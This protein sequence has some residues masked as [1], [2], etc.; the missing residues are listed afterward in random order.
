MA[1]NTLQFII[2]AQ[3]NAKQ[4]FD[5]VAA[6]LKNLQ[7]SAEG[8]KKSW[9]DTVSASQEVAIG[10]AAA[11]AAAGGFA[12]SAI[13]AAASMEQSLISYETM[14]GSA[15]KAQQFYKGLVE[16]AAKTPFTLK[17]LDESA[18]KLLA[19]G[20]NTEEVM[21]N[22]K[23]LGD[24]S[25]GVG[26][27]KLPLL[28][29][30]LGQ[31][32]AAGKMMGDT[33][34]Q[35][36]ENGVPMLE[37]LSAT[38]GKSTAE[39]SEMVSAG[40]IGRPEV[41]AALAA[42]SGEGGRFNN[43]MDKQSKSLAGLWSNL[44]DAWDQFLTGQGAM[45]LDWAKKL[46]AVLI[47]IVQNKLPAWTAQMKDLGGYL[48]KNK[49]T[50]IILAVAITSMLI[51]AAVDATLA[52]GS[53]MVALAPFAVAGGALAGLVTGLEQGNVALTTISGA[54]LALFIP[55]VIAMTTALYGAIVPMIPLIASMVVAFAPFFIGGAIVA[56]LVAGTI[57]IVQN[58][59]LVKTKVTEIWGGIAVY[60]SAAWTGITTSAQT[61]W[62]GITV[63][64]QGVWDGI[65]TVF[66][67]GAS[68]AVGLVMNYFNLFGIDIIAVWQ[69][70]TLTLQLAWTAI[71]QAF[72]ASMTFLQG[73]W[74]NVWTAIKN[75]ITPIW[76][77]I[78]TTAKGGFDWIVAKFNEVTAPINEAWTS[79]WKGV[80]QVFTTVWEGVKETIK[81]SFNWIIEK[82]NSVI[83]ALNNVA[84]TGADA[85]GFDSF[86]IPKIPALA[87]GG[88]VTRP[89]LAL[90]GEAG[91]EAVLPLSKVGGGGYGPT[92]YLTLT[93]NTFIGEDDMSDKISKQIMD[94]LRLNLKMG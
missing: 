60:L 16:F 68:L 19:Y 26:M 93:G 20:F 56:G 49:S 90:I 72:Q 94:T 91:P 13:K 48:E 85:L 10:F 77:G 86:Q 39:I 43:L 78:K 22:I 62:G 31:T 65:K 24:I 88:I 70:I 1:D 36:T 81:S 33:L 9:A 46:V 23:S 58:W 38:M 6:Q 8:M 89:T 29:L 34:R 18:K 30:A 73:I 55:S 66:E 41:Q 82:I 67:F 17:G 53:M 25:A 47:D 92:I 69:T 54:I 87:N 84:S 63:F 50:I 76:E 74:Q 15:Q 61:I 80:G 42:L 51:P 59:D 3:N 11:G 64:F 75:F 14:L 12:L 57:W 45:F 32:R 71:Q 4:A 5:Q 44:G 21:A 2:T 83:E 7:A 37:Q 35:F 40:K 79:L 52:F 28:I 27:E